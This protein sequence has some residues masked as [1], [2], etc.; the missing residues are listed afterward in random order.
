MTDAALEVGDRSHV[1]TTIE[2]EDVQQFADLSG[3]TNPL[4]LE[5]AYARQTR[6]GG[7]IAHG[8][9]V[10][11]VLSKA[12]AEIA[13]DATVV[14]LG[15]NLEFCEPVEIGAIV[16]AT[17]EVVDHHG[18]GIYRLETTVQ[19]DGEEAV[20]GGATVLVEEWPVTEGDDDE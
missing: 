1:A 16:N 9:L 4:H 6:F 18:D 14:Y 12:V 7:R 2:A 3:D 11:G 8:M 10:A 15:Q 13:T 19:A 20:T 17:A 5:D